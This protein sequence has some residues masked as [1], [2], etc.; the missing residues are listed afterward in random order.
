[1]DQIW[2]MNLRC[3]RP[4]PRFDECADT[5]PMR[6]A[7]VAMR[8]GCGSG[9]ARP[10][11]LSGVS[12]VMAPR[13]KK[14]EAARLTLAVGRSEREEG[15]SDGQQRWEGVGGDAASARRWPGAQPVLGIDVGALLHEALGRSG[16]IERRRKVQWSSPLRA[17]GDRRI[18]GGR[19]RSGG[20]KARGRAR[21]G[22]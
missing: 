4:S 2:E 17:G 6:R 21:A 14:R 5:R 8:S 16:P 9:Q 18:G 22:G 15:G 10:N 20:P 19:G 1:M 13:K 7:T 11:C 3:G 12:S